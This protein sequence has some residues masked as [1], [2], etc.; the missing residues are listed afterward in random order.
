MSA[1][2][3]PQPPP[4]AEATAQGLARSTT[5]RVLWLVAAVAVLAIVCMASIAVGAKSI[6]L[7]EVVAAL[8][9][10]G[11][12]NNQVIVGDMRV[13]R[14]L[15]GLMCG[16]ALGLAGAIMQALTRNPLADPGILGVNAGAS[17]GVV[18]GV[19]LLG[20]MSLFGYIWFA[21]AGAAL[22]SVVVYALASVGNA[23]ATPVRLALSGVAFAAVL[24]GFTQAMILMDSEVLDVF[25]FWQV[26]SL[27]GRNA[28]TVD[29]VLP[30]IAVGVVLALGLARTLNTMALGD[31]TASALGANVLVARIVGVLAVTLLCGAATAAV[32]PIGFVGLIVPHVVR[33]FTGPDQRWVLPFCLVVAPILMLLSDVLGRV[34]LST[35]ELQVGI[36]TT[37]IGGPV[38]I[39]LVRSRRTVAL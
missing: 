31:D 14:T 18:L 11:D 12:V 6:P 2:T 33:T 13:N 29:S 5:A 7:D 38:L 20:A 27:A 36:V 30:F 3:T 39:A 19:S 35:G 4:T 28:D 1:P 37:I 10:S 8:F 22:A 15:L 21:F 26:G 32:G 23:E 25:R 17:F 16:V 34:V 24:M 9:G